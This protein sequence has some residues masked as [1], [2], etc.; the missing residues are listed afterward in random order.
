MFITDD[1][2]R[3]LLIWYFTLNAHVKHPTVWQSRHTVDIRKH[4]WKAKVINLWYIFYMAM[5]TITWAAVPMITITIIT[6]VT[7]EKA[8]CMLYEFYWIVF[9]IWTIWETAK[10]RKVSGWWNKREQRQNQIKCEIF[11]WHFWCERVSFTRLSDFLCFFIV[12]YGYNVYCLKIRE[13]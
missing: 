4:R 11:R 5:V 1:I 7:T 9:I 3:A 10:K 13:S 8:A 2:A 12:R 6:W